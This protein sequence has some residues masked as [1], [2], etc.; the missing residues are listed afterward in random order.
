MPYSIIPPGKRGPGWYMRASVGGRRYEVALK[1]ANRAGAELAAAQKFAALS[2][3]PDARQEPV[4]F[5]QAADAY[6]AWKRPKDYDIKR[7]DA[8]KAHFLGVTCTAI[9]H[10]DL[11]GAAEQLRPRASNATRNR[12]VVGPAASVLHYAAAQDWCP[13]RKF[14]LFDVP[15]KSSRRPVDNDTMRLLL[16]HTEGHKRLLLAVLYERGYRI[17]EALRLREANLDLPN[18][19]IRV[20]ITKTEAGTAEADLSPELRALF[21]NAPRLPGGRV[22]PWTHRW[23]VYK[24]LRPL[25]DKLKVKY[26]P[27]QSRHAFA[28]DL[29]D[30]RVD[31]KAV[32]DA[33]A[34]LDPRSPERYR[35]VTAK[36]LPPRPVSDV[37][38][39]NPGDGAGKPLTRKSNARR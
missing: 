25:C 5:G 32:A 7:L 30:A 10:S 21:A 29:F 17:S 11:V 8:L 12:D 34:W 6:I 31:S 18:G 22:F 24:W 3:G 14:A 4:T 2:R 28:T 36:S 35:H 33:G 23:S 15:R 37:L 26:T 19:K 27:H 39:G 20:R 9:R 38:G 1:A 13:Y 16:G